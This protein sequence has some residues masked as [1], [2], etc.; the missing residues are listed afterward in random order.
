MGPLRFQKVKHL[1]TH[2]IT[3]QG[4]EQICPHVVCGDQAKTNVTQGIYISHRTRCIIGY[5]SQLQTETSSS[6]AHFYFI[7]GS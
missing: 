4:F 6:K 1:L 7:L 2:H 5:F 3:G